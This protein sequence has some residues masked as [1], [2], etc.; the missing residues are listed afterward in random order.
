M[1]KVKI[2]MSVLLAT[3]M[4]VSILAM[5]CPPPR[6]VDPVVEP[7][8]VV[9]PWPTK[10]ITLKI[11]FGAGGATDLVCRALALEMSEYL[12]VPIHALNK[13]GALGAIAGMAVHEAPHDGYTWLGIGAPVSTWPVLGHADITWNDFFGFLGVVFTTTIWVRYDSPW[14]TL[15][16]LIAAIRKD[17]GAT[18]GHPGVGSNGEIFATLLAK[19][20]GLD[21]VA[22]PYPGGRPAVLAMM[23]GEIDFASTTTGDAIDL[24]AAG[25]IR[26][27]VTLWGVEKEI[28]GVVYPS[29]VDYFPELLPYHKAVNPWFGVHVPRGVPD[30][31]IVRMVAAFEHAVAQKR[32]IDFIGGQGGMIIALTGVESDKMMAE[33]ESGRSWAVYE[34]GIAPHNPAKFG[35]PR[36]A[37]FEWPPHERAKQVRPWP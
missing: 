13:T 9:Q 21:V 28:M 12:G 6:V 14:Q 23:G 33:T 4:V 29:I 20:A 32:F 10:A 5:G 34:A 18:F 2:S 35:I 8:P 16:D 17:P 19:A 26:P 37:D 30:K 1:S 25:K 31:V 22:I 15:D 27:L 36:F 11:G 24:A 7:P 3:L